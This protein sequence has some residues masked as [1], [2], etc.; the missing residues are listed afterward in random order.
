MIKI[1]LRMRDSN[2]LKKFR[3][4]LYDS[5]F[6][7]ESIDRFVTYLGSKCISLAIKQVCKSED[8]FLI[9]DIST[10]MKIY[11][12]V[13]FDGNNI[14]LHRVYSSA[15]MKYIFFRAGVENLRGHYSKSKYSF[16][17]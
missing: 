8:L 14:R 3:Q 16:L 9:T 11:R 12:I 15:L 2:E 13:Y 10:L 7:E 1:N 6:T 17:K 4:A 5:N